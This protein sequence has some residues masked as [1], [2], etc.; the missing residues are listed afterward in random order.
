MLRVLGPEQ[1][2]TKNM[3]CERR[4]TLL[5]VRVEIG[6]NGQ[7]SADD[8]A[9]HVPMQVAT[10]ITHH[11][12]RSSGITGQFLVSRKCFRNR[13][14][15]LLVRLDDVMLFAVCA[16]GQLVATCNGDDII[17]DCLRASL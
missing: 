13:E 2:S 6:A 9:K 7:W 10:L 4:R 17:A 14:T 16:R 8:I 15:A 11:M 5:T 12:K 1:Y 3:Q